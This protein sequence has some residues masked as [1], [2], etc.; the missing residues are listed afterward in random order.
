MASP[1]SAGVEI[2]AWCP[3]CKL[4]RTHV[5]VAM[6]GTRAAKTEC[7]TCSST[8]AYR[9]NPPNTQAKRRSQYEDAMEG[10]DVSKPIAYKFTKKYNAED[11]IKHK[12]FGI[13]LVTRQISEKKI[14]VLFQES[15]KL[16]VHGR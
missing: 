15:L 16:L 1:L 2:E 8:H 4:L 5:I 9:K 11:V 12:S 6:K 13:G 14:E 10:R 7:R 3:S